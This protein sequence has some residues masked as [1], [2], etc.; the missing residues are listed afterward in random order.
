MDQPRIE[1][2]PDRAGLG[3]V[4]PQEGVRYELHM[5][6]GRP[7]IDVDSPTVGEDDLP[8]PVDEFV[9]VITD[10][11]VVPNDLRVDVRTL[12][13][14]GRG[15]LREHAPLDADTRYLLE[16]AS[17]P[18]KVYLTA[19]GGWTV[20][21]GDGRLEFA[22]PRRVD[23]DVAIRSMY[24]G[25]AA[26]VTVP[27]R[28]SADARAISLL[29]TGLDTLS[30]ERSWPTLRGHPPLFE[31]GDAFDAPDPLSPPASGI[32]LRVPPRRA[33]LYPLAPL[34]YYIGATVELE[35]GA[36]PGLEAAGEWWA[37]P[38]DDYCGTIN[39]YLRRFVYLDCL[40]R[41]VGLYEDRLVEHADLAAAVEDPVDWEQ[42]YELP[43]AERVAAYLQPRFDVVTERDLPP[44]WPTTVDL[45][46]A[47]SALGLL[48]Y[49]AGELALVRLPGDGAGSRADR[50]SESR[51]AGSATPGGRERD[52]A[53]AVHPPDVATPEHC[54]LRPERPLNACRPTPEAVRR[55]TE[56]SPGDAALSVDL[57]CNDPAMTDEILEDVYDVRDL[58]QLNLSFHLQLSRA[59]LRE[60]FEAQSD[61]V[62]YVGHVDE[63]GLRC[64]DGALDAAEVT[65][66]P[67]AV[68]L[69]ACESYDQGRKLLDA[70]AV[71][72]VVTLSEISN[73]SATRVG[74]EFARL[75]SA[76]FRVRA[77]VNM[78]Q[79]YVTIG[80]RYLSLGA[81]EL[82]LVQAPSGTPYLLEVGPGSTE[83]RY[84][85]QI[86]YF[87]TRAY[88]VGARTQPE[89]SAV[90]QPHLAAGRS[91][92]WEVDT[93]ALRSYVSRERV[94]V[95]IGGQL[96]WSDQ[97]AIVL[98]KVDGGHHEVID[99]LLRSIWS[100]GDGEE[101]L[102]LSG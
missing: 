87:P 21:R 46:A 93:D 98:Q 64:T 1:P 2:L 34:S 99:R 52:D 23:I 3:L 73:L 17:T 31:R 65:D 82:Q 33:Y 85:V 18:C 62:H 61:L 8:V 59:E 53:T 20:S 51:A 58:L 96:V 43:P 72:T 6:D 37:L 94:P 66:A 39:R 10:R 16:L 36:D 81:G 27:E 92:T 57:V 48:P 70:G 54:W 75:L 35:Q 90:E 47:P 63:A 100:T 41:T 67:Q 79:E 7:R 40:C 26:T 102:R 12:D 50:S 101:K 80:D 45:A 83:D 13:F 32:T 74:Q 56:Q 28:V 55:W 14:D 68:L 9:G 76:G 95:D 69:N 22:W 78:L 60:T 77:A 44:T 29:G 15:T 42:L 71:A 5:P 86:R 84:S 19:P 11:L 25:P 24:D 4:D 38:R 91:P 49:V 30:P 88:H 89:L 97:F